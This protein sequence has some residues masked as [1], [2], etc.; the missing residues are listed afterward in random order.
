M[1]SQ[2]LAEHGSQRLQPKPPRL[3]SACNQCNAAKVKCTGEREGCS[4]CKTLHTECIYT[5]SRVGKVQGLRS[6]RKKLELQQSASRVS[7]VDRD[8][9]DVTVTNPS[10]TQSP[11][12]HAPNSPEQNHQQWSESWVS[13]ETWTY[14]VQMLDG[15]LS[16]FSDILEDATLGSPA[17]TSGGPGDL[18]SNEHVGTTSDV[19]A[20]GY[21]LGFP[22]DR[23]SSISSSSGISSAATQSIRNRNS[24]SSPSMPTI[25]P[26]PTR[27]LPTPNSC[28]VTTPPQAKR[29]RRDPELDPE[30][31]EQNFAKL[32]SRCVLAC[33][34]ILATLEN[35]LLSELKALD[36]ILEAIRKATIELKKLVQ[37]QQQSRCD[38]CIILFTA[39]MFQV[40]ELLEVGS[41]PLPESEEDFPGGFAAGMQTHFVPALGFGAFS[42]TAEEQ[43]AWRSQL[44]RREYRHV[45]EI[46]SS[47][48][49]LARL[50]PRGASL[51][52]EMV[53]QRTKCL[54]NLER[55]L[56]DLCENQ[57]GDL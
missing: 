42:P 17:N 29:P 49:V 26:D 23:T 7:S 52:P 15:A 34:H 35:Y 56:K 48:T 27:G 5:E 38:R 4:R 54:M 24:I 20:M 40:I 10:T 3:R 18:V 19:G 43:R 13:P 57:C 22:N 25:A 44:V 41:R 32:D 37:L 46:L 1:M 33:A 47:V 2:A 39:I 28:P 9:T 14:D 12:R 45:S 30:P 50:G 55:K 11:K 53:E 8:Q 16:N 51:A 36:L 6:K 21:T 31:P